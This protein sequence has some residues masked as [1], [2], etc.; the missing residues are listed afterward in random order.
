MSKRRP[1]A[2]AALLLE[3]DA[4]LY[5][6][7]DLIITHGTPRNNKSLRTDAV[8]SRRSYKF[9]RESG[10]TKKKDNDVGTLHFER[11]EKCCPTG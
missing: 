9:D 11:S 5:L 3:F 8:Q 2:I 7:D 4:L 10:M 6:F 1:A